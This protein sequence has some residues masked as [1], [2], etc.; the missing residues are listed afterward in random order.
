[1][2]LTETAVRGTQLALLTREEALRPRVSDPRKV[3]R[4][5][6]AARN[7]VAVSVT[8]GTALGE[9]VGKDIEGTPAARWLED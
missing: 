5:V 7:W 2:A 6:H 8:Q 9:H 4:E 3:S 1:M